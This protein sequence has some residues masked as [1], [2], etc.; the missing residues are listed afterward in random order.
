VHRCDEGQRLGAC[1]LL[2]LYEHVLRLIALAQQPDD[3]AR[4]PITDYAFQ[5]QAFQRPTGLIEQVFA[6][7]HAVEHVIGNGFGQPAR[8]VA[9]PQDRIEA[10]CVKIHDLIRVPR[11]SEA[12][13]EALQDGMTERSGTR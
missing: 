13:A 4:I 3:A 2:P 5:R 1:D 6:Q 8:G 7:P 12:G 9:W 10:D 11:I